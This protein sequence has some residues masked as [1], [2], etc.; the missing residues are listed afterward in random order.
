M[1][2]AMAAGG[3][4]AQ[5]G[6]ALAVFKA[7]ADG[8]QADKALEL[9]EV[10]GRLLFASLHERSGAA[11]RGARFKPHMLAALCVAPLALQGTPG[12]GA[13]P[14]TTLHYPIHVRQS[15]EQSGRLVS[16]PVRNL[17]GQKLC[18]L[19]RLEPWQRPAA[20]Q[21]HSLPP[22]YVS[23]FVPPRLS[24]PTSTHDHHTSARPAQ[25]APQVV[26]TC[27]TG[28]RLDRALE[29]LEAMAESAMK[30]TVSDSDSEEEIGRPIE[31]STFSAVAAECL[32]QG[33]SS[34][35]EEV[36]GAAWGLGCLRC[37]GYGCNH[38]YALDVSRRLEAKGCTCAPN[39][40]CRVPGTM[41]V[42]DWRDY[43]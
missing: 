8:Q 32:K 36:G 5:Q 6:T 43:L 42:L 9:L 30:S 23:G 31:G 26:R 2:E 17:V 33:L 11:A 12:L 16:S 4:H 18:G 20:P 40:P 24:L 25:P 37:C 3:Q 21:S 7:L 28:G 1:L 39:H 35:A 41:Q 29:L 34:K 22:R 27:A 38:G 19:Q 15:M 10:G 14:C 13:T